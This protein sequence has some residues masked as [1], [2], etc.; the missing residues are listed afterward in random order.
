MRARER[1]TGSEAFYTA[2][3][4]LELVFQP[5]ETSFTLEQLGALA[6]GAGLDVLGV[7]FESVEADRAARHAYNRSAAAEGGFAHADAQDRQIDLGRWHRLEQMEPELFGR[8]HTL[9]LQKRAR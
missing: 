5:I 3:G 8:T 9:Y 6:D 2:S 1:I 7:W 4:A